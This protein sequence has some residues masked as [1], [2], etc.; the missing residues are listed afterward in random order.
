MRR[1]G[2]RRVKDQWVREGA[3]CGGENLRII[4]HY[5]HQSISPWTA[6]PCPLWPL[7]E[8]YLHL[9]SMGY[10]LSALST[11]GLLGEEWKTK[12]WQAFSLMA[13]T[14]QDRRGFH[15]KA[16]KMQFKYLPISRYAWLQHHGCSVIT[17]LAGPG[18][19]A[20][21]TALK[22]SLCSVKV[23]SKVYKSVTVMYLGRCRTDRPLGGC[24]LVFVVLYW[25]SIMGKITKVFLFG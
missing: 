2:R 11:P 4:D 7:D 13:V 12:D 6:V 16:E 19:L 8:I 14:R 17:N 10:I 25:W 18:W 3:G 9:N 24:A 15:M 20:G 5:R 23:G 21:M 1:S 22:D